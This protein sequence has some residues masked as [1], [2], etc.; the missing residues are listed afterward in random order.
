MPAGEPFDDGVEL[1]GT[2][3]LRGGPCRP[4][5][6]DVRWAVGGRVLSERG[7]TMSE[8]FSG[9]PRGARRC[10]GP[11]FGGGPKDRRQALGEALRDRLREGEGPRR[12][13]CCVKRR[14]GC[15]PPG[16]WRT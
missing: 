14:G 15:G 4:H 5:L 9:G 8:V 13:R 10:R 3:P 6:G 1:G 12:S 2:E 7:S 11:E 16:R